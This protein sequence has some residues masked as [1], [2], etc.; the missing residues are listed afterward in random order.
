MSFAEG[1]TDLL[2]DFIYDNLDEIKADYD[3]YDSDAITLDWIMKE[4]DKQELMDLY[5]L[6]QEKFKCDINDAEDSMLEAGRDK[7]RGL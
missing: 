7:D 2:N 5:F 6:I 4:F 3:L 1:A